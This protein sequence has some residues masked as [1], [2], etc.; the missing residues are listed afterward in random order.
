M[1]D[2][3]WKELHGITPELKGINNE[4]GGLRYDTGKLRWDLLPPDAMEELVRIYTRGAE[5][6]S[7]RNWEKGMRWG[8]CVRA[9]KSHLNKWERGTTFDEELTDCRHL[10]MVAWNALALLTYELRGIGEDDRP[11]IEGS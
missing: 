1:T 8:R 4:G 10:A 3:G 9:L 11:Q 6:Y 7:D 5:K 2:D